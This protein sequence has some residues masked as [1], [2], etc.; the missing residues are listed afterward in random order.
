MFTRVVKL[1]IS[2]GKEADFLHI[3]QNSRSAIR[4]FEGC[5]ALR[6][7][8]DRKYPNIF[9]TYSIW[10]SDENLQ[11]YRKSD[12]FGS[13]WRETKKLF[14]DKPEAWSLDLAWDAADNEDRNDDKI[15]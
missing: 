2:P 6:L 8:R 5:R 12:L 4:S 10:E 11:N 3:F 7:Y 1:V 13:T 15:C 14:A 9:F